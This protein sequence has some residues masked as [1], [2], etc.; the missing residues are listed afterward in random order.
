MICLHSIA[1]PSCKSKEDLRCPSCCEMN[2]KLKSQT[3]SSCPFLRM[4]HE[5]E[6]QKLFHQTGDQKCEVDKIHWNTHRHRHSSFLPTTSSTGFS[7]R[8]RLLL[9]PLACF[10]PE[11]GSFQTQ[12]RSGTIQ[13]IHSSTEQGLRM[14]TN[15]LPCHPRRSDHFAVCV[16]TQLSV[17]SRIH[18][19]FTV[20]STILFHTFVN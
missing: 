11:F 2:I 19:Y 14:G 10:F 17:C 20:L 9:K 16:S 18:V 5:Q 3:C 13:R 8:F 1:L 7:V 15:S 12:A 4:L 6:P